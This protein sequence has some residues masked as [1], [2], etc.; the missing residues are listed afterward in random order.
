MIINTSDSP[1]INFMDDIDAIRV[2]L[3]IKSNKQLNRTDSCN[4]YRCSF[5]Y[6]LGITPHI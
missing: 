3:L 4:L 2:F 5:D 6:L 1:V